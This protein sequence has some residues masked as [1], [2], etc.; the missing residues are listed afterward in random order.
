M[1]PT[2][3]APA[4]ICHVLLAG[5]TSIPWSLSATAREVDSVPEIGAHQPILVV[6]K[7]VHPQNLMVVYT[8]EDADGH[9]ITKPADRDRP[10]F[11]FYWLMD[12]RSFKPVNNLIKSEI[13]KRF[14]CQPGS[15]DRSTH[16]IVSVNDLKEVNSD[17]REPKMDIYAS[18]RSSS[19]NVEAQM[20]L[21]PSD[22]NMRIKLSSIYTEG[23]A[24][25]P[26]VY[27]VTLKGEEIVDGKPTGR[28]VVRKYDAKKTS[29]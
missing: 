7:N 29:R 14:E 28:K 3:N 16:F 8:K 17:I 26:A 10:V 13:N 4:L 25:P 2:R 22:G 5:L 6:E 21:G 23:R 12:G 27:S 19:G 1:M 20:N 11:D 24:L 15:D 9:F 18:R